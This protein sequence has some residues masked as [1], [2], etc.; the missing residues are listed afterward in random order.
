MATTF[1]EGH[2]PANLEDVQVSL[3]KVL[4][5]VR[6][7]GVIHGDVKPSN[8]IITPDKSLFLIDF[9]HARIVFGTDGEYLEMESS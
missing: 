1:I 2:H 7:R 3:D 9:S 8:L 4:D 5:Q 6:K